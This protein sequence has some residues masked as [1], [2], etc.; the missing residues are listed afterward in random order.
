MELRFVPVPGHARGAQSPRLLWVKAAG[1]E[2]PLL[3][4][5]LTGRAPTAVTEPGVTGRAQPWSSRCPRAGAALE[6]SEVTARPGQPWLG[7]GPS[8][9]GQEVDFA[10]RIPKA[11]CPS[12]SSS[13][14]WL[15]PALGSISSTTISPT[16]G[17]MDWAGLEGT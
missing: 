11:K 14:N 13:L 8:E 4:I 7:L 1:G 10:F 3:P 15:C 17:I 2:A 6:C 16:H 12:W 9:P 5:P